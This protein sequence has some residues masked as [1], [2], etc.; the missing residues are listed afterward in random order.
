MWVQLCDGWTGAGGSKMASLT[1]F[2]TSTSYKLGL[3][4]FPLVDFSP[5]SEFLH[6]L[7]VSGFQDSKSQSYANCQDLGFRI[8]TSLVPHYGR[9]SNSQSR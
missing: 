8:H 1:G 2:A 5:L 4:A 9:Q 6:R 3:L 7:L